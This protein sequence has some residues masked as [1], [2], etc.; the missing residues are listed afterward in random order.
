MTRDELIET[1]LK[2]AGRAVAAYLRRRPA[3]RHLRDD[4]YG[5][6]C[7]A[8]VKAVD[9]LTTPSDAYIVRCVQGAIAD[10]VANEHTIQIPAR[11]RYRAA[12][13]GQPIAPIEVDRLTVDLVDEQSGDPL[14]SILECC[15]DDREREKSARNCPQVRRQRIAC[16]ANRIR[17]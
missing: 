12:K 8:L 6:A 17:D 16:F 10:A 1:K 3:F 4:L 7:V 14:A 15:R 2:L 13:S 11:S 5:A 9:R